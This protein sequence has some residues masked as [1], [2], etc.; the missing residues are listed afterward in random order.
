MD[1]RH[2]L[3]LV[4]T[5][6]YEANRD[7]YV[8]MDGTPVREGVIPDDALTAY[9][10]FQPYSSIPT[11]FDLKVM[12][13]RTGSIICSGTSDA[14]M[15]SV[16]IP[17]YAFQ[18]TPANGKELAVREQW[19]C[20]EMED[21]PCFIG[22]VFNDETGGKTCHSVTVTA[23]IGIPGNASCKTP[24]PKVI[25]VQG[26]HN[27]LDE[28]ELIWED[29]VDHQEIA[30]GTWQFLMPAN[31]SWRKNIEQVPAYRG[32]RFVI[33][34]WDYTGVMN[35]ELIVPGLYRIKFE[36]LED[37]GLLETPIIDAPE[38]KKY[39]ID[40]QPEAST[41]Q[42]DDGI[43]PSTV[44]EALRNDLKK[45]AQQFLDEKLK[46]IQASTNIPDI[47]KPT[48]ATEE[49]DARIKKLVAE[50]LKISAGTTDDDAWQKE[51]ASEISS[52]LDTLKTRVDALEKQVQEQK[53]Q[54]D[55]VDSER[56][57]LMRCVTTT[58][59]PAANTY[60]CTDAM[61]YHDIMVLGIDPEHPYPATINLPKNPNAGE[62][63]Q[64]THFRID[65]GHIRVCCGDPSHKFV[66]T[67]QGQVKTGKT[68]QIP[69]YGTTIRAVYSDGF[70]YC[71]LLESR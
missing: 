2:S 71:F 31:I 64:L 51:L 10:E 26:T 16:G 21:K 58:D 44:I 43:T 14:G 48:L 53:E 39:C 70:W 36:F 22:Y 33:W 47:Q 34:E 1:N 23:R 46:D 13:T 3:V 32:Y 66:T 69:T 7:R 29:I 68:M 45:Y 9:G 67:I 28:P 42:I 20:T 65:G 55:L 4:P 56:I 40:L 17:Q 38:G 50:Q 35:K 12:T 54:L 5:E 24:T 63:V 18:K 8:A 25:S 61:N 60:D 27:T 30:P 11:K 52:L 37:E 41:V 6:T 59:D 57:I 62:C 15:G 49:I 19:L